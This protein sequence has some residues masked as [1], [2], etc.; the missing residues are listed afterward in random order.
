MMI[1]WFIEIPF[2]L[3]VAAV[4]ILYYIG[5]IVMEFLL[6]ALLVA[7]LALMAGAV[8]VFIASTGLQHYNSA[9]V[10]KCDQISLFLLINGAIL[11]IGGFLLNIVF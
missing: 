8:P 9:A 2:V 5:T 7:G 6:Q 10:K 4:F 3:I 11:F 1:I